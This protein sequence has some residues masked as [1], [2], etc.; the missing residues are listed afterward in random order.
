MRELLAKGGL[1]HSLLAP[2]SGR[3]WCLRRRRV[4]RARPLRTALRP[5]SLDLMTAPPR[6]STTFGAL[7]RWSRWQAAC[8]SG[9]ARKRCTRVASP[10]SGSSRRRCSASAIPWASGSRNGS[11]RIPRS[12]SST[13]RSR[14]RAIAA[15]TVSRSRFS[16]RT[17]RSQRPPHHARSARHTANDLRARS[18]NGRRQSTSAAPSSKPASSSMRAIRGFAYRLCVCSSECDW[19]PASAVRIASRTA[20]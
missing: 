8:R 5:P 4:S 19:R 2:I 17:E 3:R 12:S 10:P 20:T 1:V 14:S 16:T 15:F 6:A 13:S 9:R 18:T 7:R 11:R